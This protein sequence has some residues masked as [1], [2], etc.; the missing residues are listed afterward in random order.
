VRELAAGPQQT[1]ATGV[2]TVGDPQVAALWNELIPATGDSNAVAHRVYLA[3]ISS[4]ETSMLET[5][6]ELGIFETCGEDWIT[7][8][9]LAYRT[10]CDQDCLR[11]LANGLVAYG[12]LYCRASDDGDVEFSISDALNDVLGS[13]DSI[14]SL[15]G[16]VRY[17]QNVSWQYWRSLAHTVKTGAVKPVNGIS[18]ETYRELVHGIRFWAPPAVSAITKLLAESHIDATPRRLIDLGCGS[19]VYSH[20]MLQRFPQFRAVGCDD[21]RITD[22]AMKLSIEMNVADRFTVESGDLFG[23]KWPRG[24][25]YLFANIFHLFSPE[26]CSLLLSKARQC[27][28]ADGLVIIVDAIQS[29]KPLPVTPQQKFAALF[30]VSMMASGGG[31]T[32]SLDVFDEWLGEAGLARI[33]YVDTPMHGVIV[34]GPRSAADCRR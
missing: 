6:F 19:G 25:I 2:A 3:L 7:S 27:L 34:A 14:N 5:A 9:E 20:L 33:H 1:K 26:K 12:W 31:N 23:M 24:D 21:A 32:Y 28:E 10:G 8:R 17:D 16:K 11:I 13:C 4:W 15:A 29:R 30:A 18:A 22:I